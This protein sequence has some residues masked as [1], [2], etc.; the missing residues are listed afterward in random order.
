MWYTLGKYP[1]GECSK[2]LAVNLSI[3]T[4]KRGND[5][6]DVKEQGNI[7]LCFTKVILE[8]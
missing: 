4:R 5:I 7:S 1:C 6:N 8:L 3:K 2:V